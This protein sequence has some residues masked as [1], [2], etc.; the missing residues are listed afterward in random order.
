LGIIPVE[1]ADI[2]RIPEGVGAMIGLF[3]ASRQR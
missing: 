3:G 2:P 1:L